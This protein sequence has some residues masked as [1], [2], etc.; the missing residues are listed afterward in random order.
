MTVKEVIQL[1][2]NYSPSRVY[3]TEVSLDPEDSSQMV[4]KITTVSMTTDG[5]NYFTEYQTG[6]IGES[7]PFLATVQAD[8]ETA[9][10]DAG[11]AVL[12]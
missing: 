2:G 6:D 8:H 11:Y 9:L 4:L 3:A 7:A 5:P 10:E 1:A 12:S